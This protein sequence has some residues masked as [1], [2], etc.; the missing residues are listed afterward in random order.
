MKD[1]TLGSTKCKDDQLSNRVSWSLQN[2]N[3]GQN[4]VPICLSRMNENS[5]V[6]ACCEARKNN[7][8]TDCVVSDSVDVVEAGAND[9]KAVECKG[10]LKCFQYWVSNIRLTLVLSSGVTQFFTINLFC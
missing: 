6:K 1:V 7:S 2:W 5:W 8:E 9:S 10:T 3:G 4:C